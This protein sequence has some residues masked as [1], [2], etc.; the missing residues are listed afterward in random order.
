MTLS[1]ITFALSLLSKE[2]GAMVPLVIGSYLFWVDERKVARKFLWVIPHFLVLAAYLGLRKYFGFTGTFHASTL[3]VY[4]LGFISFLKGLLVYLRLLVFPNDLYFD[5]S[6]AHFLS[7]KDPQ[8]MAVIGFYGVSFLALW[9]KRKRIPKE[10]IF[11]VSWF[12]IE[13]L[14]V[15]QLV[16]SIGVRAG[17]IS[18]AEHFL[19]VACIGIL[20]LGVVWAQQ[21]F[22]WVQER[23][24]ISFAVVQI[25]VAVIY[26]HFLLTT[27]ELNFYSR[28]E[29]LMFERSLKFASYNTRIRNSLALTKAKENR[30]KEAQMDFQKVLDVDPLDVPA[31]IG[32]GKTLIDQGKFWE[33]ILE[34]EKVQ[35][36]GN[37]QELLA[38]NLKAA[39]QLITMQYQKRIASE[40]NNAQLYYSLGVVYSKT[41][42][43]AESAESYKKSVELDPNNQNALYNL[44]STLN[45]LGRPEEA[46]GFI[47]KLITIL[48]EKDAL[49]PQ[50]QEL[51]GNI[52][53][54]LVS[55]K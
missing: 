5:R 13:L 32:L 8:V 16:T 19:Y 3:D 24:V 7:F 44:A 51:L 6:I 49:Y 1:L 30:F 34:Y 29:N 41:K 23:K 42:R 33:G 20:T 17:Y 4:S 36:P 10:V 37:F 12:L 50:A 11:F 35:N 48:H 39:Y 54:R 52:R 45:A 46:L 14:P 40:P 47:E 55:A 28:D 22:T 27:I 18:L 9:Q 21:I 15:S 43:I 26:F 53:A 2:S 38:N 31:R 25:I